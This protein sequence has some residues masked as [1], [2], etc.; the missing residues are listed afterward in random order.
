[1]IGWFKH[2]PQ[3]GKYKMNITQKWVRALHVFVLITVGF[4]LLNLASNT[5]AQTL[6]SALE[7]KE[8]S[9]CVI[10]AQNRNAP[11]M[12]PDY[13]YSIFGLSGAS[14][15]FRARVTCSDGSIGQTAVAFPQAA[16]APRIAPSRKIS[17]VAAIYPP[18]VGTLRFAPL[19]ESLT[20]RR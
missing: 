16:S 10:S 13:A 14:G 5:A 9:S 1:L 4:V 3:K 12:L 2:H 19:Y 8:G 20:L 15:A 17:D 18:S 11:V 7:P 6:P